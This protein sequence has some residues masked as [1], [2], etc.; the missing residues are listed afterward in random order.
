MAMKSNREMGREPARS[1]MLISGDLT[2]EKPD[3]SLGCVT[4]RRG[5]D[6]DGK[7]WQRLFAVE[8]AYLQEAI[9]EADVGT[10]ARPT[11]LVDVVRRDEAIWTWEAPLANAPEAGEIWLLDGEKIRVLRP[12]PATGPVVYR[13]PDGREASCS[14]EKI[15]T[16]GVQLTNVPRPLLD[17]K[18]IEPE[19]SG[20]ALFE[21]HRRWAEQEI[22]RRMSSPPITTDQHTPPSGLDWACS[23]TPEHVA[24]IREI[25]R[26]WRAESPLMTVNEMRQGLG[27][28]AR[29]DA[30]LQPVAAPTHLGS[31]PIDPSW[32]L[33][34]LFT[35]IHLDEVGQAHGV[36]RFFDC[37]ESD[38]R[39]RRRI[40]RRLTQRR[41][42]RALESDHGPLAVARRAGLMAAAEPDRVY[43]E[44][45]VQDLLAALHVYEAARCGPGG[46]EA[47]TR[48]AWTF[49]L[50]R[51]PLG[52]RG[53][54]VA[55][56]AYERARDAP[57]IPGRPGAKT[58]TTVLRLAVANMN[59]R[60]AICGP[61]GVR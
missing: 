24:M 40:G 26:T 11:D 22:G 6:P 23:P 33:L 20:F 48:A 46:A 50:E 18:I 52:I 34:L 47:G 39:Y 1:E 3:G 17:F 56:E 28:R 10:F 15:R 49:G 32:E 42:D 37:P 59:D 9:A 27:L 38:T 25:A 2:I 30:E 4:V 53:Q 35:G 13:R 31:V 58:T 21:E 14:L 43:D 57:R 61:M 7:P 51:H 60:G 41:I 29:A 36:P 16:E 8:Y 19:S 12:A 54:R 44:P 45:E 5:V 55:L